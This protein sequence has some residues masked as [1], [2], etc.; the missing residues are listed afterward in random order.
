MLSPEQL[1]RLTPEQI[2]KLKEA[3]RKLENMNKRVIVVKTP[4]PKPTP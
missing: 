4:T 2:L 1:R 3:D